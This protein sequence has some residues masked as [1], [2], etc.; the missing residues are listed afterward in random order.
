M[1][2]FSPIEVK[3]FPINFLGYRKIDRKTTSLPCDEETDNIETIESV[4]IINTITL[5]IMEAR[6]IA[7]KWL[8]DLAFSAA[9][10]DLD[11]HMA[12]VSAEVKVHGIPGIEFVDYEGWKKRRRNEFHKKLLRSLTY[13]LHKI[14]AHEEDNLLFTVMET[15]K[16][17]KGQTITVNK[18]VKLKREEDGNWRVTQEWIDR[19]DRK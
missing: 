19:I 8:D 4:I 15:M 6:K 9:T 12:L 14:L 17:N 7:Q 16:S 11:A 5:R 2:V 18:A 10:W 1:F 3:K 13:R